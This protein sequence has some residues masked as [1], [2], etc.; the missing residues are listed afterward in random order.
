MASEPGEQTGEQAA[1]P[2]GK[3]RRGCQLDELRVG[4]LE[5]AGRI[6]DLFRAMD[7]NKDGTIT[8]AEFGVGKEARERERNGG[9]KQPKE[10]TL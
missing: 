2:C 1:G 6:S 7:R 9:K 8:R 10:V 4:L 5:G 3:A